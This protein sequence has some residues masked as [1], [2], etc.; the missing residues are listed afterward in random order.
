MLVLLMGFLCIDGVLGGHVWKECILFTKETDGYLNMVAV[1]MVNDIQTAYY[2]NTI[3]RHVLKHPWMEEL[4]RAEDLDSW[5][6]KVTELLLRNEQHN[7]GVTD[8]L[9]KETNHSSE[10]FIYQQMYGCELNEDGTIAVFWKNGF[11]GEDFSSFDRDKEL[12]IPATKYAQIKDKICPWNKAWNRH[13]KQYLEQ[14]CIEWL[15]KHLLYGKETLERKVAPEV[16]VYNRPDLER[17]LIALTCMATGFYPR[18]V[19]MTWVRDGET[20][21]DNAHTDGI[22][23]NE[24]ETYQIRK[25]IEIDPEDKRNYTCWVDHSSLEKQLSVT[26]AP[27]SGMESGISVLVVVGV[28]VLVLILVVVASATGFVKWRKN[29]PG[30]ACSGYT[31]AQRGE[32]EDS[33][34][35]TSS[36]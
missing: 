24:D 2:D 7:R 3:R 9:K 15:K 25:T 6:R 12:Y 5:A 10:V 30:A 34:S 16:R 35:N 18:A 1:D 23:P 32:T 29:Q 17:N 21:M 22:L 4:T 28:L 36:N 31:P 27:S 33:S 13:T 11:Q 20:Q 26:W 19:D 14:D 8:R